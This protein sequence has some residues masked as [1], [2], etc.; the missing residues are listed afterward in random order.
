MQAG[1]AND[2]RLVEGENAI[3]KILPKIEQPA[4]APQPRDLNLNILWLA[5]HPRHPRAQMLEA[6]GD[7]SLQQ[8]RILRL[9][10]ADDCA[11]A[12]N[13]IGRA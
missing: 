13:A 5:L 11:R 10:A 7:R 3:D 2:L 6:G 4:E 8:R 9:P 12:I 1:A